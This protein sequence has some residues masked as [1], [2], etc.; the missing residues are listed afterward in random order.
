MAKRRPIP[1]WKSIQQT[2]DSAEKWLDT[3]LTESVPAEDDAFEIADTGGPL[4]LP[5][6]STNPQRPRTIRAGYDY[7]TNTLT[8]IFRDGTWWEYRGVPVDL[9]TGFKTAESKGR[10]LRDSGLDNWEDMGPANVGEMPHHRRVMMNDLRDFLTYM[11]GSK[12][13]RKD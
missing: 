13:A 8:V 2:T 9:W 3:M 12:Y 11:Y 7:A 1:S 4:M 10:F 6:S 5:T